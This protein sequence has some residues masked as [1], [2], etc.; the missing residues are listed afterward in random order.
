MNRMIRSAFLSD[1]STV[2]TDALIRVEISY[3]DSATNY[4][5]FLPVRSDRRT[6]QFA[7]AVAKATITEYGMLAAI[8]FA[9][10]VVVAI[11]WFG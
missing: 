6:R 2:V 11:G 7:L 1:Q 4:R 8:F 10:V 5:E 9:S 3:L